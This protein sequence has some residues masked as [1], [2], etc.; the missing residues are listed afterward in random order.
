[1]DLLLLSFS[2]KSCTVVSHSISCFIQVFRLQSYVGGFAIVVIFFEVLYCCF[3]LYFFIR[4]IKKVKKERCGYFNNFWDILEFVLLC[5]ALACIAMYAFKHILTEV[6]MRSLK[7]Q[8][9]G[10]TQLKFAF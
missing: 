1:M 5:F 10:M 3:T 6:A 2:L 7:N 9:K 4:C 8:S